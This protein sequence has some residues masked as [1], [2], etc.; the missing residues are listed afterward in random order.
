M[1]PDQLEISGSIVSNG[2]TLTF[3]Y[4]LLALCI[5]V[6][7]LTIQSTL[8]LHVDVQFHGNDPVKQ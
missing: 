2:L 3:S 4:R 1:S 8:V 7:K 5:I 6:S